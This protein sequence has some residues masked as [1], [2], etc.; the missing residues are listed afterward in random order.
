MAGGPQPLHKA[1]WSVYLVSQPLYLN[2]LKRK[3]NLGEFLQRFPKAGRRLIKRGG[4][5]SFPFRK[6]KAEASSP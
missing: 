6:P 1:R 5:L 2:S 4:V 3:I